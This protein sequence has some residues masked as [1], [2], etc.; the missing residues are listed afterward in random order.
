VNIIVETETGAAGEE[1]LDACEFFLEVL[2]VT[3]EKDIYILVE[4]IDEC[5]LF[6]G[7][8]E[9]CHDE[10]MHEITLTPRTTRIE[11]LLTLA[12]E[13]VHLKQFELGRLKIVDDVLE[14]EGR[15]YTDEAEQPWE[16]EAEAL[17]TVLCDLFLNQ[18]PRMYK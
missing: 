6:T 16:D 8:I 15:V 12:H 1:L 5:R 11:R 10:N 13:C 14:W 7:V 9:V 17:E 2:Q 3:T 18:Y 4:P